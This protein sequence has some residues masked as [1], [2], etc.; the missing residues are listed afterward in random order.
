MS[1]KKTNKYKGIKFEDKV[2][3][4]I[5]SGGLWFDKGDISYKNYLIETKYSE[6]KGYRITLKLL[7]KIW[8]ES[9]ELNKEPVLIIG[10]KRNNK[11]IF[12]LTCKLELET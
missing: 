5:A 8:R 6:R 12:T 10:I 3:K 9:L 7:E 1:S 4:T 11:E 2:T